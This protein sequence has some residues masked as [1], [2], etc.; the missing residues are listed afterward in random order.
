MSDLGRREVDLCG[1]AD[2]DERS[3]RYVDAMAEDYK[4]ERGLLDLL[5]ELDRVADAVEAIAEM[6]GLD[7]T[8]A[9]GAELRKIAAR[10]RATRKLLNEVVRAAVELVGKQYEQLVY[11]DSPVIYRRV[12]NLRT[13]LAKLTDHLRTEEHK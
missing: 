7:V 10:S 4:P 6:E 11:Q 1:Q 12:T 8:P 2:I 3:E 13:A 5:D 9:A